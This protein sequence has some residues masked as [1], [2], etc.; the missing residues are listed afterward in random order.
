MGTGIEN[1]SPID[2]RESRRA[3]VEGRL[4]LALAFRETF[5][6]SGLRVASPGVTNSDRRRMGVYIDR[7][8]LALAIV[9]A[10]GAS[11]NASPIESLMANSLT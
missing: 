7:S 5:G 6:G 2:S 11:A 1:I 3:G 10:G 9:P 8:E 4:N